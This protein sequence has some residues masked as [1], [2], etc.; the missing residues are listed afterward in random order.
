[1]KVD[2]TDSEVV[3]DIRW[4]ADNGAFGLAVRLEV[5]LPAASREV[6]QQVIEQAHQVCPYSNATRGNV[7][8]GPRGRLTSIAPSSGPGAA[9]GP[10]GP[11]AAP[12]FDPG[13][14]SPNGPM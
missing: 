10:L 6:A 8:V 12:S 2:T 14:E 9:P 7:E 1:M 13:S 4:A 11:C 5:A 3:A